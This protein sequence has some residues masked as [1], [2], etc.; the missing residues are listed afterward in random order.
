MIELSIWVETRFAVGSVQ[1]DDNDDSE[2]KRKRSLDEQVEKMFLDARVQREPRPKIAAVERDL[3]P[4]LANVRDIDPLV[5]RTVTVQVVLSFVIS[6]SLLPHNGCL[7]QEYFGENLRRE[8]GDD[9]LVR[10]E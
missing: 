10:V 4:K 6:H 9:G 5:V 3:P 2:G 7:K 8:S 1:V